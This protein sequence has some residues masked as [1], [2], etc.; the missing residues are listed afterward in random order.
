VVQVITKPGIYLDMPAAEYFR[1]CCPQPSLSQSIAKILINQSPAHARL[2]LSSTEP[3]EY[4]KAL[5]IGNAAHKLLIGRGKEVC[6]IEANDFRTGDAKAT[7]DKAITDGYVPILAKHL[8]QAKELV[9]AAR[10]QMNA[11]LGCDRAFQ[12]GYGEV[13]IAWEEDGIWLRSMIDWVD[14]RTYVDFKTSGLSAAPHSVPNVMAAA[15]WPI[16]AAMQERGLDVLDPDGRGRRTFMFVMIENEL[17]YALSA[18]I[19][20][21]AVMTIGR[22]QVEHAARIWRTCIENDSWPTYPPI[23]NIPEMPRYAEE[24]WLQRE[25]AAEDERQQSRE[26][27]L[28]DLAG[29]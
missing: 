21:E 28:L 25:I 23:I 17:P 13:V 6:I 3:F 18:H 16:Q 20:S 5:A 15:G 22:K 27:M 10:K 11:I 29:G 19:M 2:A 8:K 4:N 12:E 14:S 24:K 9:A 26:R 1:N 7:R